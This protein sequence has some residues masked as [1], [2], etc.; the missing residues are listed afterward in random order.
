MSTSMFDLKGRVAIVTGGNG[1]IGLGFAKGLAQAGANV[2]VAA[3][4]KSK[5]TEAVKLLQ[6]MGVEALGV[7]VDVTD[8]AS[9][10]SAVITTVERFG[11]VDILV[12]NA[13]TSIRKP[14]QDYTIA[15]WDEVVNT[16]LKG[17]FFFTRAVYP[18][19]KKVGGGKIVNIGSMTSIFG[20]DWGAAYAASKGGVV[21]LTKSFALSWAKDNIQ[22]NAVL[23]GWIKTGLTSSIEKNFPQRFALIN[24][25]IP[26]GRWGE[27]DDF[28]GVAVFLASRASDYVTGSVIA[29]DGGYSSF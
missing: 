1:G 5:T 19:M 27:P 10:N 9:V 23:P 16:N 15:E 21:Q 18:H 25:R 26:Q 17:T 29:V 24:Q 7:A 22:V 6:G 4:N 28:A 12:N 3:R 2:A 11:R 20:L 8:E 14:P 13:G